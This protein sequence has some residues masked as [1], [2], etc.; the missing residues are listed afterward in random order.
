[1][2]GRILKPQLEDYLQNYSPIIKSV[3]FNPCPVAGKIPDFANSVLYPEIEG[4]RLHREFWDEQVDRCING[5]V[6]G[7]I[8]LPG[9][10]YEYLNFPSIDGPS[11][12]T[13]PYFVDLHYQLA[14][15]IEEIKRYHIPGIIIPKKR[16]AGISFFGTAI[17]NHG[18]RFIPR[19]RAGVAGGLETYVDGFR[20]KLYRTYNV[21][22]PELRVNHMIRNSEHL[23]IG[24]EEQT[25]QGFQTYIRAELFFKTMKDKAEKFEG[26][27]FNDIIL[28]ESG[29]FPLVS[30][31]KDSIIPALKEGEN[32]IGTMYIWGTGGK[33]QQ[34][35]QFRQLWNAADTLGFV[36]FCLT[37]KRYHIPYL[38]RSEGEVK[39]PNLSIKYP[40]LEPEQ[41]LGCE[42]LDAAQESI[43]RMLE[44]TAK[45]PNKSEYVKLRQGYPKNVEDIFTSSGS[46][47]FNTEKLFSQLYEIEN[48]PGRFVPY[49]LDLEKD[50]DGMVIFPL[51]VIK[52]LTNEKTPNWKK[53]WFLDGMVPSDIRDLTAAGIDGYNED[54]TQ[55]TKSLGAIIVMRQYDKF[56]YLKEA[57]DYPGR[58]PICMYYGRPPRKEQFW[59]IGLMISAYWNLQGNTMISA[60]SDAMIQFYKDNNGTKF[61]AKRPRSFDAP[62]SQVLNDY[63]AKFTGYSKP[64]VLGV[65]QTWIEDYI[66][67]C[68]LKEVIADG[69]AYD[70]ANIGTD[71]D[72]IDAVGLCLMRFI[73]MAT[74]VHT[75]PPEAKKRPSAALPRYTVNAYGD[76]VLVVEQ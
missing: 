51:N 43:D 52:T 54:Q 71:W 21:C 47:N 28:E 69:I 35:K 38:V 11:G 17:F 24:Y 25:K 27:Y 14:V 20:L 16:R 63:G 55:T 64:K 67:L 44:E 40:D 23:Q 65:V 59:M 8:H 30:D 58:V 2:D 12:P 29:Q 32:F 31:T 74:K 37:G 72:S 3:G 5:Y 15:V 66:H 73:D 46:N 57:K 7:G 33:M 61:L 13:F 76:I 36:K 19:Y 26:E 62:N 70:E 22:P 56:Q 75:A 48:S 60:E 41:L 6:T 49:E 1:M 53:V 9:F 18:M 34:S 42:D 39:M 4:T 45:L 10:Y 68:W 50:K